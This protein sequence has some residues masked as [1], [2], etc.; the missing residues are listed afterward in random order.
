MNI[1]L[2]VLKTSNPVALA[3]FY[4]QLGIKFDHHRHDTGPLH[5]AAEID[6]VV[7]EIYPLPKNREKA[8]DTL[9]LG[10]TVDD[11]TRTVE[12]LRSSGAKI[13]QEAVV[14]EW[15]YGAIVEDP[16]GRKVELKR[17][18]HG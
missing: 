12:S 4:E 8:D 18:G 14:T 5:Y 13:V 17:W 15:G 7:F 10:F 9:R 11:L 2:I 1:N 3:S 6:G 16:D